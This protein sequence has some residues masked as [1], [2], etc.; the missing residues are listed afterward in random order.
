MT[1][2][3][4]RLDVKQDT[5]SGAWFGA[6][7]VL[8]WAVY[9]IGVSIGRAEGF[10][11]ADLTFLRYFGAALALTPWLLLRQ[12]GSVAGLTPWRV[13]V[14]VCLAGPPFALLYNIGMPL[15]RL[16][17]AV[18]ISPGGAMLVSTALV[19]RS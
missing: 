7:T 11:V 4:A 12:N 18:V 15:T 5:C 13:A 9:N 1:E 8:S 10:T 19:A 3:A 2:A 17:H 16:S 6:A 14:L